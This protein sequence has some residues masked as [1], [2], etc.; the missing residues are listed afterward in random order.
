MAENWFNPS[1]IHEICLVNKMCESHTSCICMFFFS[2]RKKNLFMNALIISPADTGAHTKLK[3]RTARICSFLLC[4][5][6]SHDGGFIQVWLFHLTSRC[7]WEHLKSINI[8]NNK[9]LHTAIS[10][11]TSEVQHI[12]HL[13]G[14]FQ[15][16]TLTSPE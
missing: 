6:S 1:E 14:R 10:K 12:K 8:L 4:L 15:K 9:Q 11:K 16:N 7:L 3:K 5:S 2:C 13:N